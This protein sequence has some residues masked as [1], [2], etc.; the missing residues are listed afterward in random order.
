[1]AGLL[2]ELRG[3]GDVDSM[4]VAF[5]SII[6]GYV[7]A[8]FAVLP[9]SD[10]TVD[11]TQRPRG[12]WVRWDV[13]QQDPYFAVLEARLPQPVES[14]PSSRELSVADVPVV[15]ATVVDGCLVLCSVAKS[16]LFH[17]LTGNLINLL[18]PDIGRPFWNT[19]GLFG[20]LEAIAGDHR[21]ADFT[22]TG[23][24]YRCPLDTGQE[25]GGWASHRQWAPVQIHEAFADLVERKAWARTIDFRFEWRLE[26][27]DAKDVSGAI[28]RASVV[29]AR[30]AVSVVWDQLVVPSADAAVREREFFR[31]RQ[32]GRSYELP[33]RPLAIRYDTPVFADPSANHVLVETLRDMP[34]SSVSVYHG[35]PYLHAS[36]VDHLDGSSFAVWVVDANEITIV[37]GAR[38]S[39]SA[40]ERIVGHIVDQFREGEVDEAD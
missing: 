7:S 11:V 27:G 33:A 8:R 26:G 18:Y 40:V 34:A 13:T 15:F 5:D 25:D 12:R 17:R 6:S 31:N 9:L 32:R 19:V 20:R 1:M 21:C 14:E 4:I 23:Y 10:P 29:T 37:P 3:V 36:L 35:N 16:P 2:D 39:S 28:S 38:A 30:D 24:S 22:V